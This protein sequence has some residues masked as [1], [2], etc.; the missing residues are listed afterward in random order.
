MFDDEEKREGNPGGT[1]DLAPMSIDELED[2]IAGMEAEIARVKSEIERK[3]A[4][5]KAASGLFG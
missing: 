4:H 2:Y 1:R 3:K 5:Q